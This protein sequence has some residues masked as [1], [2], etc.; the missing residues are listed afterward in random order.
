[1]KNKKLLIILVLLLILFSPKVYAQDICSK[2]GYTILTI[3]GMLTNN[4]EAKENKENLKKRLSA[5]YNNQP[6]NV[7][8]VHNATHVG[9][10]GDLVDAVRQGLFDS[11]SDYDLVEIL[12]SASGK[13]ST[14][15]LLL[16]GHSQGNFYANNFYDKVANKEGGVPAQSIGVYGVATPDNHVAGDGKYLTSDTDTVISA[17]VGRLK[18]I[19]TPNTHIVLKNGDGLGHSFSDVYLKYRSEKIVSDIKSSF[20]K[21][22]VNETQKTEDPCISPP[23]ISMWHEL[24]KVGTTKTDFI[25]NSSIKTFLFVHNNVKNTLASLDNLLGKLMGKNTALV[26]FA[27]NS[28]E[29]EPIIIA[30]IASAEETTTV[31]DVP[32]LE[33][34]KEIESNIPIIDPVK[35]EEVLVTEPTLENDNT[36]NHSNNSNNDVVENKEEK[37]EIIVPVI[38]PIIPDTTAPDMI[39]LGDSIVNIELDGTYVELGSAVLDNK[40]GVIIATQSGTVD[41]TTLGVYLITYTA[42]DLALNTSSLIRTVNVIPKTVVATPPT[43]EDE[44]EE[45]VNDTTPPVITLIGDERIVL[46][47]IDVSKPYIDSGATVTDN[48]D[49]DVVVVTTGDD[50]DFVSN[51]IQI[52]TYTATDK[53]GNTATKTREVQVFDRIYIPNYTFG[54]GNGDGRDWQIWYF[55]GSAVYAWKDTYVNNYLREE[56]K[57]EAQAN[58]YRCM[59]CL[60]RGIFNNDPTNGF[61]IR[62]VRKIS[63]ES[64]PQNN[65]AGLIYD[66]VIQWDATG[67]TITRYQAGSIQFQYHMNISN[68][69]NGLRVGWNNGNDS[70]LIFPSGDWIG[71]SGWSKTGLSGGQFMLIP[72]YLTYDESSENR[73]L[74]T[75]DVSILSS[76]KIIKSF[77]FDL[78]EEVIGTVDNINHTVKLIVPDNVYL[79]YIV[80]SILISDRAKVSPGNL[81]SQD[82]T[83]P[84]TYMV[85]AED[86]TF[87]NYTVTVIK[88]S[89]SIPAGPTLSSAKDIISFNFNSILPNVTGTINNV[90]YTV[91]LTVPYGTA[92][93]GLSPS[94]VVSDK[95]TV[96]PPTII[97]HNFA[98]PVNFIVTAEDGTS[99][100]YI[101][102]VIV[103]PPVVVVPPIVPEYVA[104]DVIDFRVNGAKENQTLDP[105][106]NN[107]TILLTANKNVNWLT[108]TIEKIGT[109]GVYK[110]L[111]SNLDTC[112]DGASTCQKIWIGDLSSGGSLQNGEYK[113]RVRVQ[114]FIG[115]VGA[116][117]IVHEEYLPIVITVTGGV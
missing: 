81:L 76:E 59:A 42:T 35:D 100:N 18:S 67:Y 24:L 102:T 108:V 54:T 45:I 65:H 91:S 51:N 34:E 14:Q 95:A 9:G 11:K 77:D 56:F 26:G 83:N 64:N 55:N 69:K 36:S 27:D 20:D 53:S 10:L 107:M 61:N 104:P 47:R 44:E 30:D 33:I 13:V 105:A 74:E 1:M 41:T 37:E 86:G 116:T 106:T 2:N 109:A 94:I 16:V 112:V 82:F 78:D 98:T 48:A 71:I 73:I 89:D 8:Y 88:Y 58:E 21:L 49:H 6:I 103:A 39:L 22:K 92:I 62:D 96:S 101:A 31:I 29:S 113:I 80:P 7:D 110:T 25:V 117:T 79:K 70:F 4:I 3:N 66:I 115:N 57:I 50:I 46:T 15:K 99:L 85:I 52:I 38:I 17:V 23:K 111:Q 32:I 28:E 68:V 97:P 63:L 114:D 93:N 84:V 43:E 60:Q 19:M 90:N 87:V 72:P 5:T 12:D 75:P 40:D